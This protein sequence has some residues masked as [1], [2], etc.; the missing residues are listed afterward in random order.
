MTQSY[1]FKSEKTGESQIVTIYDIIA[2]GIPINSVGED[3]TLFGLSPVF[4]GDG[5]WIP[6]QKTTLEEVV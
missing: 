4:V 3:M 5:G 2:N 6:A 1:L